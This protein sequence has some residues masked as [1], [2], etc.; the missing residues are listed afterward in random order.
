M[1]VPE[2]RASLILASFDSER[3]KS[4]YYTGNYLL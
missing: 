2:T 1:P 3:A 4:M